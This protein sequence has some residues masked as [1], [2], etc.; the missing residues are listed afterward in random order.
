MTLPRPHLATDP[1]RPP[2]VDAGGNGTTGDPLLDA[3]GPEPEPGGENAGIPV[4]P[5][6]VTA[7]LVGIFGFL[8]MVRGPH[9]SVE[10]EET[11]LVAPPLARELSKPD[12]TMAAWLATHG[13]HFL[14]V[15][16][17]GA[18]VIPRAWWEVQVLRAR[19]DQMRAA[20]ES[21]S[22]YEAPSYGP[23]YRPLHPQPAG[24]DAAAPG[25]IP[26]P[27]VPPPGEGAGPLP[28]DPDAVAASV[29]GILG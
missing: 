11:A 8:A 12:T 15:L 13:D 22:Y 6:E 19:R 5:E 16:G 26:G 25:P 18:I 21:P 20:A 24:A 3:Y 1:L 29:G 7:G 2:G 23:E 4:G 10:P 9:W 14:I 27:G 17:L 28:S